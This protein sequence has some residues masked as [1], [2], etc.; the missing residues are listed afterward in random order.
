MNSRKAIND[1]LENGN[2]LVSNVRLAADHLQ[3]QHQSEI[4]ERT[5]TL[6]KLLSAEER[7]SEREYKQIEKQWPKPDTKKYNFVNCI[8]VI[9]FIMVVSLVAKLP[10]SCTRRS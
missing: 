2:E 9:C 3:S 1:V 7:E 6:Q 10:W 8:A 5:E 4:D